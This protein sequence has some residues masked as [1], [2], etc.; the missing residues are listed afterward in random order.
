MKCEPASSIIAALGG[1]K[2]VSKAAGVS[3]VT[4]QRWRFPRERGGTGGFIPRKYHDGLLEL[5]RSA[6]VEMSM[7]AF[8]DADAALALIRPPLAASPE[9]A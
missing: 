5:A 6:G 1:L 4:V 9:A 3:I 2:A 8:V 7:A